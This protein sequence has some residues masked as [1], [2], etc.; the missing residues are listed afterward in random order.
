MDLELIFLGVQKLFG[1]VPNSIAGDKNSE[2]VA[3]ET[4]VKILILFGGGL[5]EISGGC[6]EELF[7]GAHPLA[8]HLKIHP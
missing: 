3:I 1:E 4:N 6:V 7:G 8:P 5:L 2:K